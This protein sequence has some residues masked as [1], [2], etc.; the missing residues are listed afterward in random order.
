MAPPKNKR[1]EPLNV[2]EVAHMRCQSLRREC[3]SVRIGSVVYE[4]LK[5]YLEASGILDR[6][7]SSVNTKYVTS[8][9]VL[10]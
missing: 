9:G 5:Q 2:V 6:I 4:R 7:S 3:G 1:T 8:M 10:N